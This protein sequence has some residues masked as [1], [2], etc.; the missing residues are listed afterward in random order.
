VKDFPAVLGDEQPE[1]LTYI[2]VGAEKTFDLNIVLGT[3][4]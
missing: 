2:A 1:E 4:G 3:P